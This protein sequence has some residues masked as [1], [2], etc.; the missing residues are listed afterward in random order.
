MV[1]VVLDVDQK[2][3]YMQN[4]EGSVKLEALKTLAFH[5]SIPEPVKILMHDWEQGEQIGTNTNSSKSG[6]DFTVATDGITY[7]LGMVGTPGNDIYYSDIADGV[8]WNVSVVPRP[9]GSIQ[10][11]RYVNAQWLLCMHES[12]TEYVYSST[13]LQSWTQKTS[14]AGK[15][16]YIKGIGYLNGYYY[17]LR[18]YEGDSS[19]YLLQ[20]STNL[21]SWTSVKVA[22]TPAN[23]LFEYNGNIFW[24]HQGSTARFYYFNASDAA[25]GKYDSKYV[26]GFPTYPDKT[27]FMK[28]L[29]DLLV[30]L[31]PGGDLRTLPASNFT[32]GASF[33][34]IAV[35]SSSSNDAGA[36][37]IEYY[38]GVYYIWSGPYVI[39]V[40]GV[41][42][43]SGYT[44]TTHY[45][46]GNNGDTSFGWKASDKLGVMLV[47]KADTGNYYYYTSRD[48]F[49]LQA[50]IK[51]NDGNIIK[52]SDE[53]L[54]L[55]IGMEMVVYKGTNTSGSSNPTSF[56]F[57]FAPDVLIGIGYTN[58]SNQWFSFG[59]DQ[60]SA[61]KKFQAM[62]VVT[63]SYQATVGLS[64]SNDRTSLYGKK[65]A[66]GKTFYQY[67]SGSSSAAVRQ[68]NSSSYTYYILG[69]KCS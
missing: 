27:G 26:L 60:G 22:E 36:N 53:S 44:F 41:P 51:D 69:I 20:R 29:G 54:N 24:S 9:S 1:S 16:E 47:T 5:D 64:N 61:T 68:L 63:T 57:S 14:V 49:I 17:M 62:S 50:V 43:S 56:T 28:Q 34:N 8:S 37:N 19:N 30:Y 45:N 10:W 11:L 21:S 38:D 18:S 4:N 65:S 25:S 2:K 12:S 35:V 48:E 55:P 15:Y 67:Y 66:D 58:S 42:Y 32:S 6:R 3:A 7:A 13:N 31:E 33:Q 40:T 46:T 59:D 23:C 39:E 52:I